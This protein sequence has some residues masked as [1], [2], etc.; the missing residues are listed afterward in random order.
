MHKNWV[1]AGLENALAK[2]AQKRNLEDLT[3]GPV[4]TWTTDR[5]LQHMEKVLK[6]PGAKLMF[7][8]KALTGHSIPECYGAIEPTAV[9]VPLEE[10]LK[11]DHFDVC[12]TELFG[13]FQILTSY[14]DHELPHVLEACERMEQHLTA[15]VV[16]NNV[17]FVNHVLAHT[18]NGT[19]YAGMRA[20]TTGR[21]DSIS[22]LTV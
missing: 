5:M 16:S 15:A 1:D 4:L 12:T 14:G 8:G 7:G 2:Q 17:R 3:I 6:I 19:T 10:L 13:P 11:P 22:L 18:V 20:R 21:K 9:F